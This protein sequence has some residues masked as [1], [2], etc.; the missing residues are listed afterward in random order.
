MLLFLDAETDRFD[1]PE[2]IDQI[3]C[4]EIPNVEEEPE[5]HAII[6][7]NMMHGPC[8]ELNSKPPCM[9]QDAFGND[10][11]SK[12]FPKNCQPVTVTSADGYPT[13]RRRRDGRSHQVRVKD[14]LGVYRDFHMTNEWVVPYNPYLSKRYS[15][16]LSVQPD[17]EF[18]RGTQSLDYGLYLLQTSLGA[19]DRSLGQFNL[20]LPLFNWN[21]LISRMTGIQ[22]NSLILNEMSYLQD[23]EAFSYQQKYAQMNATQKHVFETITSSINSSHFYLQGP[24][25]TGKTF[26]YNTLCHFYRSHGKIV[27][28]VAS[29]GIAALLL[30][31]GRT[32]H[33][34]FAIPLNIHEQ[35]VCAIKKNDDLADLI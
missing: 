26:I 25:G 1:T 30:P 11:C 35:S 18:Y 12:K 24:A 28:C 34:R 19:Q 14:K 3:I 17:A 32:S 7:R 29:S 9:V 22:L 13:Y 4:A 10:V 27:L 23:Q 15:L 21:G 31:G 8:G 2:R 20:P 5:L 6:T 16:L 33:S